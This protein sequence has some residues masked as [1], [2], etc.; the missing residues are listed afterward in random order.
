MATSR[1]HCSQAPTL[2]KRRTTTLTGLDALL[3]I[4]SPAWVSALGSNMSKAAL[5]LLAHYADPHQVIRLGKARLTRFLYRHSRGAWG[6]AKAREL[7]AVAAQTLHCG[8]TS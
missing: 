4:L 2:I 7:L 3:E 8:V 6:Q 5:L 1:S